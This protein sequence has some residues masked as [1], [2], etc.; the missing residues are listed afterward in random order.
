M[1][2]V[3]LHAIRAPSIQLAYL[4]IHSS[5]QPANFFFSSAYC[6]F[7]VAISALQRQVMSSVELTKGHCHQRTKEVRNDPAAAVIQEYR[8][9]RAMCWREMTWSKDTKEGVF[10]D[11]MSKLVPNR[12][13]SCYQISQTFSMLPPVI[14][15]FLVLSSLVD[16]LSFLL[17][18]EMYIMVSGWENFQE[19][20]LDKDL[21][22]ASYCFIIV[23]KYELNGRLILFMLH[24]FPFRG[25]KGLREWQINGQPQPPLSRLTSFGRTTTGTD[26]VTSY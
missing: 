16:S 3:F 4:S 7:T 17:T 6:V 10:N 25:W 8:M 18:H 26:P 1:T 19:P 14:I 13:L 12:N 21:S 22:P 5:G 23:T 15:S 9:L 24:W 2:R 11:R 20:R